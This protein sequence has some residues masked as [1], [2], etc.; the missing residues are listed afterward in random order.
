MPV[1]DE[2]TDGRTDGRTDGTKFIG[3]LST[4]PGVQKTSYISG[5]NL[6]RP[7]KQTNFYVLRIFT[8]VKHR[9]I[10]YEEKMQHRDI[11]L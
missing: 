4:L 10:P 5:E 3:P 7:E 9:E 8:A 1:A 2:G 11:T 6:H